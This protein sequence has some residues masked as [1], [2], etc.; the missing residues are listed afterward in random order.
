LSDNAHMRIEIYRWFYHYIIYIV[1]EG[2]HD[3]IINFPSMF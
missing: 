3:R 1:I 2:L